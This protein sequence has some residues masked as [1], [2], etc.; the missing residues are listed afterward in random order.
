MLSVLR[1]RHLPNVLHREFYILFLLLTI[2]TP[3]QPIITL[4]FEAELKRQVKKYE[5]QNTNEQA[6]QD[7]KILFLLF[8]NLLIHH[9]LIQQFFISSRETRYLVNM[10]F[11]SRYCIY[12]WYYF[13]LNTR[14]YEI[15]S[16]P[17]VQVHRFWPWVRCVGLDCID[18]VKT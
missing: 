2:L 14:T 16:I 8:L 9:F 5:S 15:W 12:V 4:H 1:L 17:F 6:K 13:C 11:L 10:R 18:I 3:I 7:Y